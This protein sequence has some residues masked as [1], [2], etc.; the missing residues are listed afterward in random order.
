MARRKLPTEQTT[1]DSPISA[2]ENLTNIAVETADEAEN[3]E[4]TYRLIIERGEALK[5][6]P[7]SESKIYFQLALNEDDQALYLRI[8]SNDGGGLHSKE[9][10]SVELIIDTL[11]QLEGAT[12]KSTA[13][14][15]CMVGK[16]SNNAS[17]LAAILRSPDIQLIKPAEEGIFSHIL[18]ADFDAISADLLSRKP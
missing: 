9:W 5:L 3:N 14:K 1:A 6:S 11:K 15:S 4:P 7:K 17:F 2:A 13:L 12:F 16:S 8:D 18:V 10:I